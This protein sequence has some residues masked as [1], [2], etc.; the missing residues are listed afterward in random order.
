MAREGTETAAAAR[1]KREGRAGASLRSYPYQPSLSS[2][3]NGPAMIM[4]SERC[5]RP[6]AGLALKLLTPEGGRRIA[7]PKDRP[8]DGPVDGGHSMKDRKRKAREAVLLF[9][10]K[11]TR[12]ATFLAFRNHCEKV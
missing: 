8:G 5:P 3:V 1:Q 9:K 6:P 4:R 7:V 12:G 11:M 10:T 2:L